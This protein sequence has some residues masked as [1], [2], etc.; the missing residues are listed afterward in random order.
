MSQGTASFIGMCLKG[1][2]ELGNL[3]LDI[4]QAIAVLPLLL[5]KLLPM[6]H[7]LDGAAS[8]LTV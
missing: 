6:L 4:A 7:V 1:E 2:V 8:G 3:S 5:H